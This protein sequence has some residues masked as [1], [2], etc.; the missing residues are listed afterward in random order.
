MYA[1]RKPDKKK[2][3]PTLFYTAF[4]L[5]L[6]ICAAA[7][8]AAAVRLWHNWQRYEAAKQMP[9]AVVVVDTVENDVP[10]RSSVPVQ[11]KE[12]A[13]KEV[14]AIE[15]MEPEEITEPKNPVPIAIDFDALLSV[16]GDVVGW[17]YCPGTS[18]NY[19]ILQSEG[20]PDGLFVD[21][22]LWQNPNT[23]IYSPLDALTGY[24][25]QDYYEKH[26]EIW[27]LTPD[28]NYCIHLLGGREIPSDARFFFPKD[29]AEAEKEMLHV[30]EKSTFI[31]P[32][33]IRGRLVTICA[34]AGE[35]GE[36]RFAVFGL[37]K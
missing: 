10:A 13:A 22:V 25:G 18:I 36:S 2:I 35:S 3:S 9:P 26:P 7:Y 12:P 5:I 4:F 15:A 17:L 30:M 27:L 31:A 16:N 11:A 37:T 24:T 19:P 32:A 20:Y 14:P 6:P 21:G 1:Q 34:S 28:E 33:Q 23:V 29:H 8:M